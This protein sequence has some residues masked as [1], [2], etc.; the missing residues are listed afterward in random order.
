MINSLSHP[1]CVAVMTNQ[2]KSYI[3]KMKKTAYFTPETIDKKSRVMLRE[4]NALRRSNPVMFIPG[5]SA[6][7][8]LDMQ[9]YFFDSGSHAY[10]PSASSIVQRVKQLA[11]K[12][13]KQH[14]L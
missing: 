14:L 8:I 1:G 10:I 11:I 6:L 13:T 2:K 5:H 3:F 7:L 12:Y 9:D 4:L